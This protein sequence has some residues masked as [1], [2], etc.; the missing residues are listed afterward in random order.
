MYHKLSVSQVAV[1][2]VDGDENE[3]AKQRDIRVY[4]RSGVPIKILYYYG[5]YD[6]LQY[7]I[8]LPYGDLRWLEGISKNTKGKRK[9]KAK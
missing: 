9:I 7:L 4:T 8:M 2:W 6:P 5:C 1:L 3:E